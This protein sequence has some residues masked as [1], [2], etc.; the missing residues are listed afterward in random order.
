MRAAGFPGE[1]LRRLRR[2]DSGVALVEFAFSFPVLLAFGLG[3][4]ELAHYSVTH[5]RLSQIAMNTADNASRVR[6]AIDETDVNELFLGAEL[7]GASFRFKEN[8]RIILSSLEMNPKGDGQWIRWQRCFG[9]KNHPSTYG[10]QG[11]GKNDKSLKGLGP[12]GRQIAALPASAVIFAEA[13]YDYRP[14]VPNPITGRT[15]ITYTAAYNIRDR[16]NNEITNLSNGPVAS[17]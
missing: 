17:C 1:I 4:I 16:D 13:V 14:I 3:G 6:T 7:T 9:S 2:A 5:M 12:P 11:D 15:T 10:K 8:G